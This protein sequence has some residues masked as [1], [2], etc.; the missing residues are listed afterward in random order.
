MVLSPLIPFILSLK[1]MELKGMFTLV[2]MDD[3]HCF[4]N[5][6]VGG[7]ISDSP[8]SLYSRLL[9][10]TL[11]TWENGEEMARKWHRILH[12]LNWIPFDHI[13][14]QDDPKKASGPNLVTHLN[15]PP[16]FAWN[17]AMCGSNIWHTKKPSIWKKSDVVFENRLKHYRV[18]NVCSM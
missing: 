14:Q 10:I 16:T 12:V 18:K 6:L 7:E 1:S 5:S 15:C 17:V 8:T 2:T 9:Y 13:L 11:T 4:L 3:D